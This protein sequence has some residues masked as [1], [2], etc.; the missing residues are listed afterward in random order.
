[1]RGEK[2]CEKD[3][4]PLVDEIVDNGNNTSFGL[5]DVSL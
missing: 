5:T 1:M 3:L 2:Y 4:K